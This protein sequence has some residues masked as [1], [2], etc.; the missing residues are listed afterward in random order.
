MK[1]KINI[2]DLLFLIKWVE[3]FNLVEGKPFKYQNLLDQSNTYK[4]N[5]TPLDT[6]IFNIDNFMVDV[7]KCYQKIKESRDDAIKIID[8][9]DVSLF[10]N[11][12]MKDIMISETDR[13]E[14]ILEDLMVN[15]KYEY[16]EIR[17]IQRFFL[18]QKL[19]EYIKSEE[20]EKCADIRNIISEF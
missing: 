20:Y 12:N 14:L 15:Y 3:T 11:F 2:D 16:P 19:R 8:M 4:I 17:G 18:I 10:S 6:T 1:N 13:F 5:N 7:F 9:I